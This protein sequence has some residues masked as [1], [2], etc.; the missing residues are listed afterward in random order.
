[1]KPENIVIVLELC[2]SEHAGALAHNSTAC[3]KTPFTEAH[4][5]AA[6]PQ[7]Y[8]PQQTHLNAACV[9]VQIV[10][11]TISF[12]ATQVVNQIVSST[13]TLQPPATPSSQR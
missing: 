8:T 2:V 3:L 1:V 6:A 12:T 5:Q 4:L 13:H 9:N 10:S 11:D 7:G